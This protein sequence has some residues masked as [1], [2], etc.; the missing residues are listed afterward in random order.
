[1]EGKAIRNASPVNSPKR[2]HKHIR[3]FPV[4][5]VF[6]CMLPGILHYTIFR[7]FPSTMTAVLSFTDI[8]GI[9]GSAW[10]W[11]GWD[12]YREFF[13]LQNIRDLKASLGRTA[14]Y[15][16][17]V[18][19]IQNALALLMAVI[20]NGKFLTGRNFARAVYF[21]PVILGA[22]VV[23]TIWKLVFSTPTGPIY[24]FMQNVLGI[25]NPPA[26]LSSYSYAFP[27]VIAAQIWQNMG[28]SMVI[29]LAALQNISAD[30]YEAAYIDGA[31][32]WQVFWKI[33]LPLIWS[34]VTVNTLLAIIG[35]LQSFE[36][37]MTKNRGQFNTKTLGINVF[38]TAFGGGGATASGGTVA[39]MRQGYA[40]AESM[41]LFVGVLIVTVISQAIM[42]KMEADQ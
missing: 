39:G 20:L 40:A 5:V 35:S 11:I 23:S 38:D 1:M 32:E 4:W 3:A 16:L 29:F 37:N 12:N 21:M 30:L 25:E 36:H 7:L 15:A 31:S 19:L 41:V 17:S 14:I 6:L 28:Y 9:P 22:A 10:Q 8:S 34:S 24:L 26:I 27:A 33:T 2:R 13:I 42:K 18:T